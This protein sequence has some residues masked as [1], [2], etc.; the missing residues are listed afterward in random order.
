MP[1]IKHTLAALALLLC[2]FWSA[3]SF[4]LP[5]NDFQVSLDSTD[6]AE[7]SI[8]GSNEPLYVLVRY[9][10]ETPLRFQAV[11]TR[12]GVVL[13]VGAVKNPAGL[14]APGRSEALAWVS[15]TNETHVD[16]VMVMVM[17]ESW[18]LLDSVSKAVDVKWQREEVAQ[19]RQPSEWVG[20]LIRAE[21][22]KMDYFY[23]PEP[24]KYETLFDLIFFLNIGAIPIYILLQL[25]MLWH[26]RYRWRELAIIPLFPYMIV[27]FY[28]LVGLDIETSMLVT[29][30]FRYTACAL[31]YL[32]AL[33]LAKR[34]WQNK[35]PPPKLYKPPKS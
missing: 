18:S 29:F 35:L 21:Q 17:D 24:Q 22:R 31:L 5:D 13:E 26:Y 16:A 12:N 3:S 19:P 27:A 4:A 9:E 33:W 11:A 30:L 34:F 15:Y 6:P 8:L 10:S 1:K 14:H 28:E 2:C 23:D 25:H 32:C 7:T 20:S